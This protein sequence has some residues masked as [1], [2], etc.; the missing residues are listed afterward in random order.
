[1]AGCAEKL[2]AVMNQTKILKEFFGI[3]R[4]FRYNI[5]GLKPSGNI[6]T[7]GII[8]PN[9]PRSRSINDNYFLFCHQ[10]RGGEGHLR[11]T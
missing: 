3:K 6:I 8:S 7:S 5:L 4:D 1:M 11:H 2:D 10:M 9:T